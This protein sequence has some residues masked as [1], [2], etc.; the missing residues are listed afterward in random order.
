MAVNPDVKLYMQGLQVSLL[1]DVPPRADRLVVEKFA[2]DN[3]R[4]HKKQ[5]VEHLSDFCF[6]PAFHAA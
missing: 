5:P 2:E 6:G 3:A 4:T 1:A